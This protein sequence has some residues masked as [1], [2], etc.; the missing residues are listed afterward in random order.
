MAISGAS[1]NGEPDLDLVAVAE[2]VLAGQQGAVADHEHRPGQHLQA[3]QEVGHAADVGHLDGPVGRAQ[4]G[5]HEHDERLPALGPPGECP[6]SA[7]WPTPFRRSPQIGELSWSWAILTVCGTVPTS[8]LPAT[9]RRSWGAPTTPGTGP[10]TRSPARPGGCGRATGPGPW[11]TVPSWSRPRR[12]TAATGSGSPASATACWCCAVT[13]RRGATGPGCPCPASTPPSPPAAWNARAWPAGT[14]V[15]AAGP[16]ATPR[17]VPA[18]SPRSSRAPAG[19]TPPPDP[20][21]LG[22]DGG[23]GGRAL[24][25][26]G[27]L[28]QEQPE[29]HLGQPA[30]GL[31]PQ[32]GGGPAQDQGGGQ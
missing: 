13:A 15:S 16:P 27:R 12:A 5:G 20:H 21:G 26:G 14:T 32:D 24:A 29:D 1:G 18:P 2:L 4:A 3:G 11:T 6:P 10:P 7:G 31:L 22:Q 23:A 30:G 9:C 19:P 8:A 17:P 28:P 25:L